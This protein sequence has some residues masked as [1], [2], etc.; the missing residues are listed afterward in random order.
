M[1]ETD[2]PDTAMATGNDAGTPGEQ[3]VLTPAD[4]SGRAEADILTAVEQEAPLHV[5]VEDAPDPDTPV[6]K[7]P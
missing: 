2:A 4:A 5:R 7:E 1:D 6:F 3:S